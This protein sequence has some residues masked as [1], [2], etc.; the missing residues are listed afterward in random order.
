MNQDISLHWVDAV[1]HAPVLPPWAA[2]FW[3]CKNRYANQSQLLQVL[4]LLLSPLLFFFLLLPSSSSF[5]LL[6]SSSSS[7]SFFLPLLSCL[8]SSLLYSCNDLIEFSP[9]VANGYYS[10]GINV[11]V[12]VIDYMHWPLM[13]DWEF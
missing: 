7:S 6:P 13:G 2:G 11:S 1:G 10:R 5:L 3:Q 12:I 8:V 4:S 9:K